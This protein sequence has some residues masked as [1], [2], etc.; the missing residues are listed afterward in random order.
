MEKLVGIGYTKSFTGLK[1]GSR[2]LFDHVRAETPEQTF[3]YGTIELSNHL[4]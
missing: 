1:Y 2:K 3:R 4:F